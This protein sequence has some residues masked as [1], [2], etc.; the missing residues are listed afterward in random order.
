MIIIAILFI[1]IVVI[2]YFCWNISTWFPLK[3]ICAHHCMAN[4][5]ATNKKTTLFK[6][7]WFKFQ[8]S[9]RCCFF[10]TLLCKKFTLCWLGCLPH[11]LRDV[12]RDDNFKHSSSTAANEFCEWF[13]VEIDVYIPHRRYQVK[14]HSFLWF[15]AACVAEIAQRNHIFRLYQKNNSSESKVKFRQAS[16]CYKRVL[17]TAKFA[18]ANKTKQPITFHK[19]DSQVFWRIANSVLNKGKPTIP[20]LFNGPE[21]LSSALIKQNYLLK[22]FLRTLILITLVSLYLFSFPELTWNCTIFP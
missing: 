2:I 10:I 18:Y 16:N 19:L 4:K 5:T 13:H 8:Y 9:T 17:E 12:Q 6:E 20:P 7:I 3:N 14:P 11:H 22:T 15:S 1:E 21:V